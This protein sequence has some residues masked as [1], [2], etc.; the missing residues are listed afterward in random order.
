ML[1]LFM[2]YPFI[3]LYIHGRSFVL[4]SRETREIWNSRNRRHLKLEMWTNFGENISFNLLQFRSSNSSWLFLF[5]RPFI[6]SCDSWYFAFDSFSVFFSFPLWSFQ[7]SLS[8]SLMLSL[9]F[10]PSLPR[11]VEVSSFLWINK[12]TPFSLEDHTTWTV[13]RMSLKSTWRSS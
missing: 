5:F 12:K 6:L 9:L 3:F 13:T 8:Y 4:Q 7:L 10:F 2:N 1:N 11:A